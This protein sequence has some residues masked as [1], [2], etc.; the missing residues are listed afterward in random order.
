MAL[1]DRP[2]VLVIEDDPAICDV[3]QRHLEEDAYDVTVVADGPAGLSAAR[4]LEP[5]LIVLDAELPRVSG[6]DVCQQLRQTDG[7]AVPIILLTTA[8]ACG[9]D[10]AH[11]ASGADD[12]VA[13]PFNAAELTLRVGSVLRRSL[14]PLGPRPVAGLLMDGDLTLN[15]VSREAL[16][17]GARLPLTTRE[18][19]LLH[20]LLRH[21]RRVFSDDDLLTQVWGWDYRDRSTV[22][23]H[24]DRVR[25][26]VEADPAMPSRL[27]TVD[28]G[29]Y[30][31]DPAP[32]GE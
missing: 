20:F 29:G 1:G 8:A 13:K 11:S 32:A 26:H 21:P 24:V 9:D 31:W 3:L 6:L 14:V 5:D 12:Y 16:Q 27:V 19:D 7:P 15:P 4:D 28:D 22:A 23:V 18:F 10:L 17:D 30:R 2:H 25:H